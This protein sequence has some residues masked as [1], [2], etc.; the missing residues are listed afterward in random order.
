VS[1]AAVTRGTAT[2]SLQVPGVLGFEGSYSVIHQGDAGILTGVAGAG[3]TIEAGG[4]LYSVANQQVRLLLGTVPAYREFTAGMTDGP[5]VRQLE[6]GLT[7][8][9]MDPGHRMRVDDHF[10]SATAA[11]IKR[12]EAAWGR[13]PSRR[14]GALA[15]G[16]IVFHPTELRIGQVKAELGTTVGP[17]TPVLA[18]TSTTPAVTARVAIDRRSLVDIGDAVLVSF[19]GAAPT[20]GKVTDVGGP[21]GDPSAPAGPTTVP[22]TIAVDRAVAGTVSDA[23]PVRVSITTAVHEG[24]LL[25]PVTALLAR[26][27]GGYQVRTAS[28]EFRQVQP[29]LFDEAAGLVEVSGAGLT[30]DTRVQVPST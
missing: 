27:E 16:R 18:T 5:D 26:P 29:G 24:V 20:Q 13:P 21:S 8:L 10:D 11:A 25:V 19:T 15:L 6:Q 1:T 3:S 30:E 12:W 4:V 17:D 28:G 2:E 9:G 23:T 7:G 14:T 22:V